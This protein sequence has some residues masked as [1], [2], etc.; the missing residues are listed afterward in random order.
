MTVHLGPLAVRRGV[1][2]RRRRR[3]GE[4]EREREREEEDG[5]H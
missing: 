4:R 3:R 2:R 5:G 1:A